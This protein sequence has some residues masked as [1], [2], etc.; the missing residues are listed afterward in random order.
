MALTGALA[1]DD[2][3][4]CFYYMVCVLLNFYNLYMIDK[5]I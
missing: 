2:D 3:L 1:E 5:Q 4:F